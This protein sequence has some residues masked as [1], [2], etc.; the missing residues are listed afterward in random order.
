[1]LAHIAH[2]THTHV[3]KLFPT[4]SRVRHKSSCIAGRG[5]PPDAMDPSRAWTQCPLEDEQCCNQARAPVH[6]AQCPLEDEPPAAPKFWAKL[7]L[8]EAV[9]ENRS[10]ARGPRSASRRSEVGTCRVDVPAVECEAAPPI[11]HQRLDWRCP[12]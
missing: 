4:R 5:V 7:S 8:D 3:G 1:M 9:P 11:K 6:W 10:N 12:P 2:I